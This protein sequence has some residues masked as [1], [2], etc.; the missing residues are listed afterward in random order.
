MA[1]RQDVAPIALVGKG[2]T[3]DSGGYSIKRRMAWLQ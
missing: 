1:K 2:I 3:Y